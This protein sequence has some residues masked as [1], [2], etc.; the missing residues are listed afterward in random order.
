[1]IGV[2]GTFKVHDHWEEPSIIWSIVG[3]R[4]GKKKKK[5]LNLKSTV[6]P[7]TRCRR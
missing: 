7:F 2:N 4:K 6:N 5:V 1:M 3:G